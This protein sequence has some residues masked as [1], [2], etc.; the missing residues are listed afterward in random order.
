MRISSFLRATA[1]GEGEGPGNDEDTAPMKGS[2]R[3]TRRVLLRAVN[4]SIRHLDVT[5]V[6]PLDKD[7]S[8]IQ[9][10]FI[11]REIRKF[12]KSENLENYTSRGFRV[13]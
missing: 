9:L 13:R 8:R 1:A 11:T 5:S 6:A 4:A 7:L 12:Q 10:I 2:I 3:R